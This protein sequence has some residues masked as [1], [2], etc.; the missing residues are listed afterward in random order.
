[1]CDGLRL[2]ELAQTLRLIVMPLSSHSYYTVSCVGVEPQTLK[3]LYCFFLCVAIIFQIGVTALMIAS[4]NG[5]VEVVNTLLKHE[6]SVDLKD[7][8]HFLLLCT[9]SAHLHLLLPRI[10]GFYYTRTTHV[11]KAH[12]MCIIM[13]KN[14]HLVSHHLLRRN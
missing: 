4:L 11:N 12:A 10:L 1:M 13:K 2:R 9:T 14:M 7:K 5:R 6:A 3:L 8:V